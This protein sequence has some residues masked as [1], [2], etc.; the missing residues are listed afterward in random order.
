MFLLLRVA[1]GTDATAR[2][3]APWTCCEAVHHSPLSK[4]SGADT[5][6]SVRMNSLRRGLQRRPPTRPGRWADRRARPAARVP[7]R[8]GLAN[9]ACGRACEGAGASAGGPMLE[10]IRVVQVRVTGRAGHGGTAVRVTCMLTGIVADVAYGCRCGCCWQC[11]EK[12]EKLVGAAT[13]TAASTPGPARET[14][15]DH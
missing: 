11:A 12:L 14:I 2:H 3:G 7:P 5:P 9:G 4:E 13:L 1:A 8:P 6:I 10:G 15:G